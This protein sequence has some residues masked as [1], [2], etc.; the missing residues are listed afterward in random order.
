MYIFEITIF[1]L[2]AEDKEKTSTSPKHAVKT[3]STQKLQKPTGKTTQKLII[4]ENINK[5]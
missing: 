2:G 1:P 4:T 3:T 5:I